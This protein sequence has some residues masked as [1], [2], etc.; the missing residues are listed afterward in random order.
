MIVLSC[1][2]PLYNKTE[3]EA[4]MNTPLNEYPRPQLERESYESLNGCWEYEIIGEKTMK[5]IIN[6]PFPPESRKSGVQ[7]IIKP[8]DTL[9]YRRNVEFKGDFNPDIDTLILHFDA[10][11]YEAIVMVDG[12]EEAHH[13]GG[14]LPFEIKLRKP[15]FSLEVIVKDPTDTEEIERGKQKLRHGGIWYTPISGIWQS[16][17]IEKVS[18]GY[19]ERIKLEP[20]LNGFYITAKTESHDISLKLDGNEYALTGNKREFINIHSPHL[21]SPDDPYLYHFTLETENDT[22]RSYVGLR[23]FGIDER[24][25]LLN[26]NPIYHHGILD[27]GY[28]EDGIYTPSSYN[29]MENDLLYIKSLGFNAIRKHIKIEPLRWYYYADTIGLLVWQDMIN[30]GGNYKALTVKTPLVIGSFLNDRRNH[31]AFSRSSALM[32]RRW[33]DNAEST[34]RHLYNSTSIALWTIFNEGWGQFDSERIKKKLESIDSSRP[35]DAD[36]GWHDQGL[37]PFKS[38]H[39][40]FRKYRFRKDR[41]GRVVIL[42]EFGG[43]GLKIDAHSPDGKTFVYKRL[44][45]KEELTA[46]IERLYEEEIIP[47]KK[48]GLAAS[49][50]TQLSDVEE[51]V[52]GLITADRKEI[53]IIPQRIRK[54]SEKLINA[55]NG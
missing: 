42:S 25:M 34:I 46:E 43:Y 50:Y 36:S 7:H 54:L 15:S 30:G 31:K 2:I 40:Y 6:V 11:D 12:K 33:E 44:R 38:E 3:K 27:Q 51:E 20:E 10:V 48:K 19:I 39:V 28:F 13:Y 26:G 37:P 23:T 21:W 55:D 29:E 24:G 22:V 17:W 53:K 45:T 9:I 49:I 4:Q 52:N 16:V 5:G 14:Y 32:M 1:M 35:Y 8:D 41:K 18:E 47:A